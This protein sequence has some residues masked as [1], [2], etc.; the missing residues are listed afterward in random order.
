M[1]KSSCLPKAVEATQNPSRQ[2]GTMRATPP[3]PGDVVRQR[4]L[5]SLGIKQTD[6]A[7]AMGV[8]PV[9]INQILRGRR[10]ISIEMALRLGK[11]TGTSPDYWLRLQ[12]KFDIFHARE[13]LATELNM[14]SSLQTSR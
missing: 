1:V 2:T 12:H 6:L 9:R 10:P 4:I 8:S 11:V 7:R 14:L 3:L 13:R 5:R